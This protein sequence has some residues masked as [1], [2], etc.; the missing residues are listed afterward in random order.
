MNQ[1]KQEEPGEGGGIGAAREVA[2]VG[3]RRRIN[4]FFFY[5]M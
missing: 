1:K 5:Q 3:S 4:F 2:R